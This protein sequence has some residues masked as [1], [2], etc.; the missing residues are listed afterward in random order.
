MSRNI[1][2][3]LVPSNRDII[4]PSKSPLHRP[5]AA[6]KVPTFIEDINAWWIRCDLANP[7]IQVLAGNH[8]FHNR[9][10]N[11]VSLQIFKKALRI[12]IVLEPRLLSQPDSLI[13][14][15]SYDTYE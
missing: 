1:P 10:W 4:W 3:V 6:L 5:I 7:S 14:F 15:E 8:L 12:I 9:R 11:L 13:F 2:V